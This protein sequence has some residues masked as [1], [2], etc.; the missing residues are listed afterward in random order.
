M[1]KN[2]AFINSIV[3]DRENIPPNPMEEDFSNSMR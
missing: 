2:K 1:S 3:T